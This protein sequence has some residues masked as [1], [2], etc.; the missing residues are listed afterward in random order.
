MITTNGETLSVGY[1]LE[2]NDPKVP[3]P[4]IGRKGKH[5]SSTAVASDMGSRVAAH[6]KLGPP[7]DFSNASDI[8]GF[9]SS[10]CLRF[11]GVDPGATSTI[12]AME[13]LANG[14]F[15]S[16]ILT[17]AA[18]RNQTNADFRISQAKLWMRDL[19][20]DSLYKASRALSPKT[21]DVEEYL[22]WAA[23]DTQT[24]PLVLAQ[25]L[26]AKWLNADF[27]A[28]QSRGSVL[29]AFW[30][31]VKAGLLVDNTAGVTAIIGYGDA[32]FNASQK[33]RVPGPTSAVYAACRD[34]IGTAN[35]FLIPEH[36]TTRTCACC[37][38]LLQIVYQ[39]G[40]SA[41]E[42][43]RRGARDNQARE[44]A[45]L[46][47]LPPLPRRLLPLWRESHGLRRCVNA[48]CL[49]ANQFVSRD[50]NAAVN[51]VKRLCAEL[52]GWIPHHLQSGVSRTES[53][54][55]R[56]YLERTHPH[57]P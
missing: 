32:R 46:F 6:Y 52:C 38:D 23:L 12:T 54:P 17:R 44:K 22:K 43:K 41:F 34:V 56:F 7:V 53:M 33:G 37:G 40:D 15:R 4:L 51:M 10:M 26:Q 3:Y 30:G 42:A 16:W 29:R 24:A 48:D 2:F 5:A 39:N 35:T 25:K 18:W 21:C 55:P 47:G 28:W 27:R 19:E 45:L 13:P 57:S 36:R 49:R 1:E 11:I 31:R 14:G 50:G 8:G 9:A 20:G